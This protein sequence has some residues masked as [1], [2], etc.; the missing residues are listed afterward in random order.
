MLNHN[1]A[2]S[3][4]KANCNYIERYNEDTGV[5]MR[6]IESTADLSTVQFEEYL[7][8]CREFI[9]EWFGVRVPLPNEQC[10]LELK[11]N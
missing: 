10:E 6:S 9:L 1:D 4:L 5:I 7:T 3:E 2:H 11:N 8:R